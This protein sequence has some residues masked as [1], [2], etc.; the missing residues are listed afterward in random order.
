M[1]SP[2]K[3]K[4]RKTM[5]RLRRLDGV[6]SRGCTLEFG[7]YGLRTLDA[8]WINAREIEAARVAISR[9]L[10]RGG[11]MWIRIFPDHPLT[12]KP[13]ETRQG[14]GKGAPEKWVAEVRPGRVMYE[15]TGVSEAIAKVALARAA[16]KMSVRSEFIKRRE[17][18]M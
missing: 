12:M 8:G 10:K 3:V 18:L 15:V 14:S 2:K 17:T 13:A 4:H 11:K 5:K 6:E 1:L 7:E 16:A 9:E